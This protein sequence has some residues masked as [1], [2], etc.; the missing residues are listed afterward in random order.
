MCTNRTSIVT[1]PRKQSSKSHAL[2]HLGRAIGPMAVGCT[3]LLS[4]LSTSAKAAD[5][6]GAVAMKCDTSQY[7]APNGLSF[8][9]VVVMPT[10]TNNAVATGSGSVGNPKSK[11]THRPGG[12]DGGISITAGAF[13]GGAAVIS[14][15]IEDFSGN[16]ASI[17]IAVT[18]TCPKDDPKKTVTGGKMIPQVPPVPPGPVPPVTDPPKPPKGGGHTLGFN[19]I[20]THVHSYCPACEPIAKQLNA[21]IDKLSAEMKVTPAGILVGPESAAADYQQYEVL[22]AELKDCEKQRLRELHC[23]QTTDQP[24]VT[25]GQPVAVVIDLRRQ[26]DRVRTQ[27]ESHKTAKTEQPAASRTVEKRPSQTATPEK[28]G[29]NQTVSA[30]NEAKLPSKISRNAAAHMSTL[31]HGGGFRGLGAMRMSGLHTAGFGAPHM[32]GFGG[33]HINHLTRR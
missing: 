18:V 6:T 14:Y 13:P 25:F 24:A 7:L 22:L 23:L 27:D 5:Y 32:G 17:D 28:R 1:S 33:M 12:T 31:S 16:R 26:D 2:R 9:N 8:Q 19:R 20:P 30:R 3:I 15:V 10:S 4:I 21:V 29:V 11:G